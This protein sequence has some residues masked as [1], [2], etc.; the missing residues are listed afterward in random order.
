MKHT[1]NNSQI[2]SLL[3]K[4][5]YASWSL[6]EAK[7]LADYYEQFEEDTGTELEFD[8]VAIRCDWSYYETWQEVG[9][10]FACNRSTEKGIRDWIEQRGFQVIELAPYGDADGVLISQS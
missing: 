2:I 10:S 7:A 4:D 8:A 9:E 6:P 1:L 5:E 3:L